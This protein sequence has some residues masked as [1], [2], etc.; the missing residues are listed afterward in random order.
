MELDAK[1][2][3]IKTTVYLMEEEVLAKGLQ[4]DGGY[5][6]GSSICCDSGIVYG[7]PPFSCAHSSLVWV[8]TKSDALK[9][10]AP[11]KSTDANIETVAACQTKCA[12]KSAAHMS[13]YATNYWDTGMRGTCMCR[14]T[15]T[16]ASG[17]EY[18]EGWMHKYIVSG[19]VSCSGLTQGPKDRSL[20]ANSVT[21]RASSMSSGTATCPDDGHSNKAYGD[22]MFGAK[23]Q[24]A[25]VHVY[26]ADTSAENFAKFYWEEKVKGDSETTWASVKSTYYTPTTK[27]RSECKALADG[28]SGK[29]HWTS[30]DG[31]IWGDLQFLCIIS[32]TMSSDCEAGAYGEWVTG[33]HSC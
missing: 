21:N 3:T 18:S 14:A 12:E 2:T 7:Q 15:V 16:C 17:K 33:S 31:A 20:V 8:F 23:C 28:T 11:T 4:Y 19:P 9:N 30:Y 1:Q 6:G 27:T 22:Q 10:M 24:A 13:W 26:S 29:D 5:G 25:I 32:T